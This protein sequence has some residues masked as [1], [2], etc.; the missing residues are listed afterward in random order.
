[1]RAR[2][3]EHVALARAAQRHLEFAHAIHGIGRHPGEWDTGSDS[4]LDHATGKP[5]L[6]GELDRFGNVGGRAPGRV[7]RPCFG[8]IQRAVDERV[9]MARHVGGED[10]DLAVGVLP[11]EPV[12]CRP[13]PQDALPCLRKPVSSI[14]S[15]ASGSASVSS[16]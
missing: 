12:Y 16:A 9:A 14:T 8:Q 11:A 4:T 13:T 15:T 3:P 6:G 7:L 1:M 2:D 5:W 10:P